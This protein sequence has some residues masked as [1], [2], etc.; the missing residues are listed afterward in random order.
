M[1]RVSIWKKWHVIYAFFFVRKI[2]AHWVTF[3]F[4]CIVIPA[5]IL[6][7]EVHLSKSVHLLVFW[8]LFENVMSLH[9]SKATIIGL[10]EANR[11]NEWVLF[12]SSLLL[13]STAMAEEEESEEKDAKRMARL[14]SLSEKFSHLRAKF[15]IFRRCIAL[16]VC[17]QEINE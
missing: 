13:P 16:L 7:P 12:H 3:F 5:T 14:R 1:Q 2:I 15:Y 4:Y 17:W 9:R 6:V 10:L 11:A 8:V